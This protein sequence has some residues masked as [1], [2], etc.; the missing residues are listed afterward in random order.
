MKLLIE[1]NNGIYLALPFNITAVE[2]TNGEEVQ[3]PVTQ[4]LEQCSMVE[5][6]YCDGYKYVSLKAMKLDSV[7]MRDCHLVSEDSFNKMKE[8][9]DKKNEDS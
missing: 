8:E 5:K 6:R 9:E 7:M 2:P 1:L 4:L 3:V